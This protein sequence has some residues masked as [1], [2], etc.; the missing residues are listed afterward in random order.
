MHSLSGSRVSAPPSRSNGSLMLAASQ[1]GTGVPQIRR[2]ILP[3]DPVFAGAPRQAPRPSMFFTPP[4]ESRKEE[5]PRRQPVIQAMIPG[6]NS[7]RPRFGKS[8]PTW[9]SSKIESRAPKPSSLFSWLRPVEGNTDFGALEGFKNTGNTCY[10]NS[11][12]TALLHLPAFVHVLMN[13]EVAR[14]I[15]SKQRPAAAPAPA[16][17]DLTSDDE[18]DDVAA[19][20]WENPAPLFTSLR[21]LAVKR[22]ESSEVIN[23]AEF[24][25]VCRISFVS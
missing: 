19:K 22:L 25:A 3:P 7:T 11:V 4:H 13:D 18:G 12:I 15:K 20:P 2:N 23:P 9:G 8:L 5:T 10:L 21:S 14:A 17:V 24:K 6:T 16:V 1:N